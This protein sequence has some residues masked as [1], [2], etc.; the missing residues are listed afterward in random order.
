M[1]ELTASR[2]IMAPLPS[3][4]GFWVA[5]GLETEILDVLETELE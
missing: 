5:P 4:A 1:G 2:L 3:W